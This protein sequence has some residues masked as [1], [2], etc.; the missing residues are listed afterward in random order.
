MRCANKR[1]SMAHTQ[2]KEVINI[3][4]PWGSPD[5]GL[6]RQSNIFIATLNTFNELKEIIL[7]Y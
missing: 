7:K 3:K 6:T 2:E 4:C 5:I 1:E